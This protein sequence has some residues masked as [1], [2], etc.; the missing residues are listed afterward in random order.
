MTTAVEPVWSVA[1]ATQTYGNFI[2]GKRDERQKTMF[3][4]R[5]S[6]VQGWESKVEHISRLEDI[7]ADFGDGP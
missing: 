6:I 3:S 1:Q 5:E 7:L 2:I 4:E